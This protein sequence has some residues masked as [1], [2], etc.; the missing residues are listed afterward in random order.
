MSTVADRNA[1]GAF[2]F[3]ASWWR[4][5]RA[6]NAT[7]RELDGCGSEETARIARDIGV[8]R[9]ELQTL[10]GKWPDAADLLS[11][12]MSALGLEREQFSQ[13]EPPVLRDL[14]RVCSQCGHGSPCERDLDHDPANRAWRG[15]CPNTVT[16]DALRSEARDRRPLRKPAQ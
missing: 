14:E 16:F 9:S 4:N 7:R 6:R 2:D 15:Y 13:T 5:W 10:A 3:V 11:R 12:R 1:A 8:S